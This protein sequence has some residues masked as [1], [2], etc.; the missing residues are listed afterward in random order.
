M[1]QSLTALSYVVTT[2]TLAFVIQSHSVQN[3]LGVSLATTAPEK[4]AVVLRRACYH[5]NVSA[6]LTFLSE[7][8]RNSTVVITVVSIDMNVTVQY[9]TVVTVTCF[10]A[11]TV[12]KM[13]ASSSITRKHVSPTTN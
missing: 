10:C 8:P 1:S 6:L 5:P 9:G 2:L 7:A 4:V 12:E 11:I 13:I 3:L